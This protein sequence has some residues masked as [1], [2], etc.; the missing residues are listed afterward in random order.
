MIAHSE[1]KRS[2]S[3]NV[4]IINDRGLHARAS[5]KFVT[6]VN[7]LPNKLLVSVSKG[8]HKAI[9]NSIMGLM[10]LGA[11]KGSEIKI[12]IEYS[13]TDKPEAQSALKRLIGL[14]LD[15]FGED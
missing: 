3:E 1:S 14:V 5:S 4:V 13:E 6:M 7:R 2:I 8:E 11:A 9:G 10:M 12:G 15:G